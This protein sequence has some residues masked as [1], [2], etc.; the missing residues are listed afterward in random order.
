MN[1]RH[2]WPHLQHYGFSQLDENDWDD[3]DPSIR[4]I[5]RLQAAQQYAQQ[6]AYRPGSQQFAQDPITTWGEV[7][8]DYEDGQPIR[9]T[10]LFQVLPAQPFVISQGG[11][12]VESLHQFA[13][14]HPMSMDLRSL[15][16]HLR[17]THGQARIP[18]GVKIYLPHH[19]SHPL[20]AA[21]HAVH[22]PNFAHRHGYG[23]GAAEGG[24]DPSFDMSMV[25]DAVAGGGGSPGGPGPS[26]DAGGGGSDFGSGPVQSVIDA[27]R[28]EAQGA[29]VPPGAVDKQNNTPQPDHRAAS[30]STTFTKPVPAAAPAAAPGLAPK[31]PSASASGSATGGG[32]TAK[33]DNTTWIVAGVAGGAALIGILLAVGLKKSR[34]AA[35]AAPII[36]T[37]A[38][39]ENPRA[40]RPVVHTIDEL[41]DA[42]DGKRI[43]YEGIPVTIKAE[44]SQGPA[45]RKPYSTI[46]LLPTAQARRSNAKY[47]E[48]KSKYRDDWDFDVT[49]STKF[50]SKVVTK[51]VDYR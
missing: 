27:S 45:S 3:R 40:K 36:L 17:Y 41:Y 50:W 12:T 9:E 23:L 43:T 26:P 24:G 33:T 44:R 18:A 29:D 7:R 46:A 32:D 35:A 16:P 38:A 34:G 11:M 21:G 28:G 10:G 2:D 1:S 8:F 4:E 37:T 30:S 39:K 15:N 51:L 31:Y 49:N 42:I 25:A 48:Q 47:L 6:Y 5:A 13:G 20:Q 19:W 22:R 14:Q